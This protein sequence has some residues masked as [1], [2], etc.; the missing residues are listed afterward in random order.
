MRLVAHRIGKQSGLRSPRNFNRAK[1]A[2]WNGGN[3][4][5]FTG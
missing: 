2:A 4:V 5:G 3:L 1:Y